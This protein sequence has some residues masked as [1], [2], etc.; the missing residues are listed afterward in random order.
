[1]VSYC[2]IFHWLAILR[3][4]S[5]IPVLGERDSHYIERLSAPI[6]LNHVASRNVSFMRMKM[7]IILTQLKYYDSSNLYSN[8]IWINNAPYYFGA[9]VHQLM[10][11]C[12]CLFQSSILVSNLFMSYLTL[13]SIYTRGCHIILLC[14][15]YN[16]QQSKF[17]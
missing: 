14:L 5:S 15:K 8:C 16:W 13:K 3:Y 9:C 1:M 12:L 7:R 10:F 11:T 6:L 17:N 2:S 4:T